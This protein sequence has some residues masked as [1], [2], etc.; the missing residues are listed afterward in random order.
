MSILFRINMLKNIV[1]IVLILSQIQL[2]AQNEPMSFD[3]KL[4]LAGGNYISSTAPGK[5]FIISVS[6]SGEV[7]IDMNIEL[8]DEKTK[9]TNY[10]EIKCSAAGELQNDGNTMTAKGQGSILVYEKEELDENW[11]ITANFKGQIVTGNGLAT[12]SGTLEAVQGEDIV[13]STFTGESKA[14]EGLRLTFPLGESPKVFD[15]G[16]KFGAECLLADSRGSVT[17]YSISIEWTGTATFN[18]A[19]GPVSAP[20]F[21]TIG[22]NRIILTVTDYEGN[23][24]QKEIDVTTVDSK[25][26]AH[27]GSYAY[28]PADAHGCKGCPHPVAGTINTGSPDVMINGFRAARKG[29]GGIQAI[30]CGPNTFTISEGDPDVLIKGIPAARYGNAT[31]HC[32]GTGS[33][34]KK[35]ITLCSIIRMNDSVEITNANGQKIIRDSYMQ[36]YH[37]YKGVTYQTKSGGLF[38]MSLIPNGLLTAGP[39]TTLQVISDEAGKIRLKITE[40]TIKFNGHSKGPGE[41]VIELVDETLVLKGTAFTLDV[42]SASTT[43]NLLEG[44]VD[45]QFSKSGEIVEIQQGEKIVTNHQTIVTRTNVDTSEVNQQ[46][47]KIAENASGVVMTEIESKVVEDNWW[48]GFVTIRMAII[49]VGSILLIIVLVILFRFFSKRKKNRKIKK[50][51]HENSAYQSVSI[52]NAPPIVQSQHTNFSPKFC[53]KCG[54][55]TKVGARFCSKCGYKLL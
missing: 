53:P 35:Q 8:R 27:V 28:C 44:S 3:C 45:F 23:K 52:P 40:G 36:T 18:P 50:E 20:I 5:R 41:V 42:S 21:N 4:N 13:H 31:K 19:T 15:K 54:V 47:N 39:N 46:W 38:T 48:T 14:E 26:Y 22:A 24:L 12:I 32:G 16:W 10:V 7:S 29:D 11:E 6:K 33:L 25:E 43:L 37:G 1:S 34:V 49:I 2:F 17:D 9:E 55:P 30:C 51:L